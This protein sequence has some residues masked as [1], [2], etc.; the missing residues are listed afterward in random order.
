MP[1]TLQQASVLKRLGTVHIVHVDNTQFLYTIAFETAVTDRN[2]RRQNLFFLTCNSCWSPPPQRTCYI[3][4]CHRWMSA[5]NGCYPRDQSLL[6]NKKPFP[7][8][9]WCHKLPTSTSHQI[10]FHKIIN[11]NPA[12]WSP[13][14]LSTPSHI[15]CVQ[16]FYTRIH[17]RL[18][19]LC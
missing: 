15:S 7:S 17:P 14:W 12:T 5:S 11:N 16:T 19:E 13:S 1:P 9:V 6:R 2:T 3:V 4:E 8:N 18:T 10:H